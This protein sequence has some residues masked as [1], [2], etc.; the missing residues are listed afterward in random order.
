MADV[1][2]VKE[3]KEKKSK[4]IATSDPLGENPKSKYSS[5]ILFFWNAFAYFS[6]LVTPKKSFMDGI[7]GVFAKD[8]KT[9]KSSGAL[10]ESPHKSPTS[11]NGPGMHV[12]HIWCDIDLYRLILH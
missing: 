5:L 6:N 11:H 7:K 3:K 10:L 12:V 4:A 9:H 1:P 2:S 8:G